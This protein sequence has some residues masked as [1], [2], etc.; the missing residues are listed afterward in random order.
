M[1]NISTNDVVV[2]EIM[3]QGFKGL[4]LSRITAL[5]PDY[6]QIDASQTSIF[7][8]PD[9]NPNYNNDII[10]YFDIISVVDAKYLKIPD[11]ILADFPNFIN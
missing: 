6:V 7:H 2:F 10:S 8:H 9:L 1:R 11:L 3:T 4:A 5:F